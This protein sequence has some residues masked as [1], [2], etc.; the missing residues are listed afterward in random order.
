MIHN[1]LTYQTYTFSRQG[2]LEAA[3][4]LAI[5]YLEAVMGKGGE[6]FGLESSLMANQR[7]A[8]VPWTVLDRLFLELA[9][10][11]A[12]PALS[13]AMKRC[14]WC[15]FFWFIILYL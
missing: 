13:T 1:D 10:N 7:P 15:L 2:K 4:E 8:W 5:E 3:S 12:I 9:D 14:G 11:V 6:Y